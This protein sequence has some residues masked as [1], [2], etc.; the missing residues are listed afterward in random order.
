MDV[1]VGRVGGPESTLH[2]S[3][4]PAPQWWNGAEGAPEK[5]Y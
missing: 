4:N 2:L 3:E 5:D 1:N